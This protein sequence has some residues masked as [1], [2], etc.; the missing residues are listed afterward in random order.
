MGGSVLWTVK[1]SLRKR[2]GCGEICQRD[3][4]FAVAGKCGNDRGYL[5]C[6]GAHFET[7]CAEGEI[8]IFGKDYLDVI[9]VGAAFQIFATGIVRSSAIMEALFLRW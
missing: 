6:N 8:L 5:F 7:V 4:S 1:K 9:V 2:G 3:T